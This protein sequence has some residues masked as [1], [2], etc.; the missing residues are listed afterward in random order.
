MGCD[1]VLGSEGECA[2]GPGE[3]GVVGE[4]ADD[5]G[6]LGA[7][8]EGVQDGRGG[9]VETLPGADVVAGAGRGLVVRELAGGGADVDGGADQAGSDAAGRRGQVGPPA[10]EV[11]QAWPAQWIFAEEAFGPDRGA[12]EVVAGCGVDEDQ[13]GAGD[14]PLGVGDEQDG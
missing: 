2:R 6:E 3:G 13:A 12:Q 1:V 11:P 7:R 4:L 9:A 10:R 5:V 14:E 8:L